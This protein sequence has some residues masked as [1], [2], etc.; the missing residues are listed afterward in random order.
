[1]VNNAP[2]NPNQLVAIPNDS[3]YHYAD[4][5]QRRWWRGNATGGVARGK[6]PPPASLVPLPLRGRIERPIKH[7]GDGMC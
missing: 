2:T 5:R 7:K 6:P 4:R 3:R 1:V